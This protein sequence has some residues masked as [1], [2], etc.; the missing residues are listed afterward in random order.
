[1][2]SEQNDW[3]IDGIQFSILSEKEIINRAIT[4]IN[5]TKLKEDDIPV[6]GGLLDNRL[7]N[8]LRIRQQYKML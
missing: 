2:S 6:K 5:K 1:M 4:E 3:N 8:R 7:N